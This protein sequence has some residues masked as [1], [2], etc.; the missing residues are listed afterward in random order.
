MAILIIYLVSIIVA[1]LAFLGTRLTVK[2][3]RRRLQIAFAVALVA[4]LLLFVL[5]PSIWPLSDVLVMLVSVLLGSYISGSLT[6]PSSIV[7][8]CITASIADIISFSGGVSA[9][10]MTDYAQGKSPFLQYLAVSLPLGGIVAP[11]IGLG[12]I[13]ILS[14]IFYAFAKIGYRGLA[15]F[16][17]PLAGLLIALTVGFLVGG[18]FAL[19]FISAT[20]ILYLWLQ[21][22]NSTSAAPATCNTPT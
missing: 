2:L 13:I 17:F 14:S 9:K 11:L 18:I 19:P 7:A 20:T 16:L 21:S 3:E 4:Y 12:D 22:R 15:S 1:W 8:F 6:T 5:R 10:I